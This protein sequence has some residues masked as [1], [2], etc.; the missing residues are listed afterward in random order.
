DLWLGDVLEGIAAI[1]QGIGHPEMQN[2]PIVWTGF[3]DGSSSGVAAAGYI[4]ERVLAIAHNDGAINVY[5]A[6]NTSD[7][8]GVPMPTELLDIPLLF[9]ER[10]NAD[11][12]EDFFIDNRAEGA[13]WSRASIHT[14]TEH[15]SAGLAW[16][17]VFYYL[18][19]VAKGRYPTNAKAAVHADL[20]KIR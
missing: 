16:P 9:C 19:E 2:A 11:Y 5:D 6:W 10:E 13:L 14:R 20:T 8:Q 7:I 18:S 17:V 1:A 15:S 3:S 12:F 4:P